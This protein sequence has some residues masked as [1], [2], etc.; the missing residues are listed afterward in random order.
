MMGCEGDGVGG[1]GVVSAPNA[2]S[3]RDGVGARFPRPMQDA[4]VEV[5]GFVPN[6]GLFLVPWLCLGIST[7]ILQK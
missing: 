5:R 2:G 7:E 1:R 4:A 6:A 3:D